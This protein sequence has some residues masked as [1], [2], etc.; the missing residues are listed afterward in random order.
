VA[1]EAVQPTHLKIAICVPTSGQVEA[2][3]LAS[4]IKLYTQFNNEMA[5]LA[6]GLTVSFG[7]FARQSCIIYRNR[8]CLVKDA[9]ASEAT[10]VLFLDDDMI[11]DPEVVPMLVAR[12]LPIV[13]VNYPMRTFPIE[14]T[15]RTLDEKGRIK[16]TKDSTGLEEASF[17]GFGVSLIETR[18]FA[19]IEQPWFFPKYLPEINDVTTEDV[20]FFEKAR[21]AGFKCM[22]DHDASKLVAHM[23]Q[24][25]Y[26][27]NEA[28]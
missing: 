19:A 4:I 3:F 16:T 2:M 24:H 18:V 10:H 6:P 5:K 8:M 20:Y 13:A 27:W 15:A 9:I 17:A 11:F 28:G 7:Y 25:R 12:R 21:A 23:G 14:F 22:I 26:M 1:D